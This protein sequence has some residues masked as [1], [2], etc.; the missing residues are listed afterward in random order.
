MAVYTHLDRNDL[1]DFLRPYQLGELV[2]HE[3]ILEGIENSNYQVITETGRFILTLFEKRVCPEDLPFFLGLMRHLAAKGLRCPVPIAG[4][5]G[6]VLRELKQRPAV[7]VSFL[8]G[9]WPR[10]PTRD[11]CRQLGAALAE[12]HLAGGDFPLTRNNDLSLAGW[13]P[14]FEASAD[15]ADEIQDGLTHELSAELGWL[16]KH[17]PTDL[18]KGVIHADLFPDN[19]FFEGEELSGLI[20][21]YFACTD[22]LAYDLAVCLNA[23]CFPDHRDYDRDRA[24]ALLDGYQGVRPLDAAEIQALPILARG[25]ALRFLL[26]RLYDWLHHPKGAHVRPKDPL[27][28]L[29]RLRATRA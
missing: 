6:L 19:V 27:E 7:M 15:R 9:T 5:D 8:D 4:R 20:D 12:L 21:F 28:Y 11:H 1:E 22:M 10:H 26:T 14:L 13:R 2:S 3:G 23:W 16:E 25:A 29:A 24:T 17:W 18:P